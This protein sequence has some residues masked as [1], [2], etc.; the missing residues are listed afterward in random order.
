RGI[1]VE[2]SWAQ[3]N[4][5]L[6]VNA[7]NPDNGG[8]YGDVSINHYQI[9][10]VQHFGNDK[11]LRPFLG[12]SGGWSTFNPENNNQDQ[13]VDYLN[14]YSTFTFGI[15]GGIKYMFTNHIGLRVQSQLLLPIYGS[16]SY[17]YYPSYYGYSRVAAMLNF[18]GGLIFAFGDRDTTTTFN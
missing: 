6:E 13:D 12:M 4:S 16:S 5:E 9:G 8:D 10:G 15:S 11:D 2:F 17:Y 18:S 1:A 3:Q 14:S 7:P